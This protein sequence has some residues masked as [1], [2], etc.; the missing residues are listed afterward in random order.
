MIK[1][2]YGIF[3]A[4]FLNN[5]AIKFERNITKKVLSKYY[6]DFNIYFSQKKED[7]FT[8]IT[9][10]TTR[11]GISPIFLSALIVELF[12]TIFIVSFIFLNSSKEALI[13]IS[14]I[15]VIFL[16]FF[17]FLIK[18]LKNIVLK[19]V[20]FFKK[21]NNLIKEFLDGIREVIIFDSGHKFFKKYDEF[22]LKQLKPQRDINIY[23]SMPKIIFEGIVFFIIITIVFY[24]TKNLND[25]DQIFLSL[26]IFV[27][28][29]VRLLPSINRI[30][31]NFNNLKFCHEPVEKIFNDL[32]YD[33]NHN[34]EIYN[35]DEK[36][37]LND[38]DFNY[39]SLTIF[40]KLNLTINKTEKILIIGDSGIG[41]T[42]LLDV[43]IGFKN[44]LMEEF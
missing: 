15:G 7:L 24:T 21:K 2:I 1:I 10:R 17:S 28:L 5:F 44:P 22:N 30:L 26:G 37:S 40:S 20:P 16:I 6:R 32:I 3:Y 38:I 36:L 27:A 33:L 11:V 9:F 34:N 12:M 31:L 13:M 39:G 19:E 8:S 14:S 42:T 35:F 23:N 4:W 25:T 18:L 43:I 41:K 29:M